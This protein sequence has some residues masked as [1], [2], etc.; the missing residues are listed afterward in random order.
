MTLSC[1]LCHRGWEI[2][3][4]T[5]DLHPHS[6]GIMEIPRLLAIRASLYRALLC[7]CMDTCFQSCVPQWVT[8]DRNSAEV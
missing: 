8:T 2:T 1:C 3:E 7:A 6:K 4:H 5:S